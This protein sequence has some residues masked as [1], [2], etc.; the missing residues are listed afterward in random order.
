MSRTSTILLPLTMLL[1]FVAGCDEVWKSKAKRS[2]TQSVGHLTDTGLDVKTHNG[3]VEVITLASAT[4]VQIDVDFQCVGNTQEE[5]DTRVEGATVLAERDD[6]Q[7]LRI[8]P[9]FPGGKRNGDGASFRITLPS[10]NDVTI[11][12]SNGSVT[13]DGTTGVLIADTSNGNIKV[14]GHVIQPSDKRVKTDFKEVSNWCSR[15]DSHSRRAVYDRA[16][17][18]C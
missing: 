16:W 9:Q 5:A 18:N 17:Y 12:T 8:T 10:A 3:S 13:V 7:V 14:T 1:L 6:Q 4:A 11:D 15:C 2:F